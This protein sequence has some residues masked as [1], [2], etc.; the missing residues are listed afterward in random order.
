MNKRITVGFVALAATFG[1]AGTF[2]SKLSAD[3]HRF[4][5]QPNSIVP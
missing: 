4:K 1:L 3:D 2:I 5:F